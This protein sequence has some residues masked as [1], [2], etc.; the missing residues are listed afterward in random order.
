MKENE[1][2]KKESYTNKDFSVRRVSRERLIKEGLI[3]VTEINK[4]YEDIIYSEED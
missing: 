4:E 1:G 2:I 3:K